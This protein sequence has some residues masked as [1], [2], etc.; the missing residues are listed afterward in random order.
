MQPG[1]PGEFRCVRMA[2]QLN[3]LRIL[4]RIASGGAQQFP[5]MGFAA[6]RCGKITCVPVCRSGSAWIWQTTKLHLETASHPEEGIFV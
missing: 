6:S 2:R 3:K 1:K 4:G 5:A